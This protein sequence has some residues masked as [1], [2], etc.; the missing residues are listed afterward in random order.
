[1]IGPDEIFEKY[2]HESFRR[3]YNFWT[4]HGSPDGP[5]R[6]AGLDLMEIYPIVPMLVL[7]DLEGEM[8]GEHRFKW[9][10]AG[11]LLRNLVGVEM[12]GRYLDEIATPEMTVLSDETYC[13]IL[14]TR[15][16]HVWRQEVAIQTTDRSY[17]EYDRLLLPLLGAS[18]EAEHLIGVYAFDVD[19]TL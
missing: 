18:G 12:T 13:G 2:P 3:L 5:A 7:V 16:P 8:T 15:E 10:L 1:M 11:T 14:R 19:A 6:L 9:R 17:V 4:R